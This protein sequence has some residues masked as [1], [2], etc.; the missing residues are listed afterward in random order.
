MAKNRYFKTTAGVPFEI[1][2][3][4][5][6]PVA[7]GVTAET[8]NDVITSGTVGEVR[9]MRFDST[10]DTPYTVVANTALAAAYAKQQVCLSYVT[11]TGQV[12]NTAP[13]VANTISAKVVAYAA[14]TLQVMTCLNAGF[15]V[16]SLQ[17]RLSF[18][19]IE[20]T[21]GA[22]PL[23]KWNYDEAFLAGE[24]AAFTAIATKINLGK[25][26]EF[27]TA[28]AGP[29]GITITSTD[30]SRHFRLAA[31]V[32]LTKAD[33]AESGVT[34]TMTQTTPASEGSGTLD[35]VERLFEE[36]MVRDGVT[37]YYVD[38][39]GTNPSEFGLP[40]KVAD[41]IATTTFDIVVLSGYKTEASKTPQNVLSSP[42]YVFV[43]VP[44][45]E[46]SKISAIFA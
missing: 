33:P 19:I 28:V 41:T 22:E 36:A 26:N 29:T 38:Q 30:A 39:A 18:K 15:G 42:F 32:I 13:M 40:T 23:P 4:S 12:R 7:G 16:V 44:A 27:F 45:G 35:Q 8:M 25:D 34:Y 17:Q 5:S 2:F 24:A 3:G 9:V 31:D 1:A 11:A 10:L 43:A 21:P 37:H 46:G 20:T 14:P 6:V